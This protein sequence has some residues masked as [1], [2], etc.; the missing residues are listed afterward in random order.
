MHP[1]ADRAAEQHLDDL[2]DHLAAARQHHQIHSQILDRH[3][4]IPAGTTRQ[5]DYGA[6]PALPLTQF[7]AWSRTLALTMH[8][9]DE[10]GRVLPAWA[11]HRPPHETTPAFEAQRLTRTLDLHRDTIPC[12]V[13]VLAQHLGITISAWQHW[14]DATACPDLHT[15]TRACMAL[16][17]RITLIPLWHEPTLTDLRAL[18]SDSQWTPTTSHDQPATEPP[19]GRQAAADPLGDVAAQRPCSEAAEE[20]KRQN[21]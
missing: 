3:L 19:E 15:V 10:H 20:G 7:T 4:H 13:Q 6:Y 1:A 9:T 21:G 17:V 14:N 18:Q 12:D 5:R 2:F 11:P 16:N 8:L